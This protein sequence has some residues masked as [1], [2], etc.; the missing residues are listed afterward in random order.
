MGDGAAGSLICWSG[1][2]SAAIL[3]LQNGGLVG[4]QKKQVVAV[5]KLEVKEGIGQE[6]RLG[7]ETFRGPLS[8][9]ICY[10]IG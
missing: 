6:D 10:L 4:G 2:T 7:Q 8:L 1:L 9:S 3:S 5:Q